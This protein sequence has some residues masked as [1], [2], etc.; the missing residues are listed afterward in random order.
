MTPFRYGTGVDVQRLRIPLRLPNAND[1]I[2]AAT[3]QFRKNGKVVGNA[4]RQMKGTW[5]GTLALLARSQG[6]AC[7]EG[8]HFTYIF[9]EPNRKRDPSNVVIGGLKLIEDALQEAGLLG[10]DGWNH[11]KSIRVRWVHNKE[12][13]G[14]ILLVTSKP[15]TEGQIDEWSKNFE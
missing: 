13:G 6:F 11:V 12:F 4:Y 14:V 9:H 1:L 7:R 3:Q 15:P 5:A 2:E 10:N 8:G